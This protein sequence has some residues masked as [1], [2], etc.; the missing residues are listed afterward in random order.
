M[1]S[2]IRTSALAC[3]QRDT[4]AIQRR[5]QMAHALTHFGGP[6]DVVVSAKLMWR[7][8]DIGEAIAHEQP[9]QRDRIRARG[10][11]VIE[12]GQAMAMHVDTARNVVPLQPRNLRRGQ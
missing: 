6:V 2:S 9:T 11:P 8:D 3:T 7:G 4:L 12:P 5:L 10:R 1:R